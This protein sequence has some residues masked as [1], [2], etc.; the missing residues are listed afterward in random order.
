[1]SWTNGEYSIVSLPLSTCFLIIFF[2]S[3]LNKIDRKLHILLI[4]LKIEGFEFFF[5]LDLV[6]QN[7]IGTVN[8]TMWFILDIIVLFTM[9]N[10]CN[11]VSSDRPLDTPIQSLYKGADCDLVSAGKIWS[12]CFCK[13][14]FINK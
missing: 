10:S 9:Q 3:C 5:W 13:N 1:M 7:V 11:W 6:T 2:P 12:E 4:Q 8:C 14:Y